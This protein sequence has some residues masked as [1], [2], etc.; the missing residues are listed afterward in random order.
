[1]IQWVW[2]RARRV[3]GLSRVLVATDDARIAAAAAG[4]GGEVVMTSPS[5]PSGSDRA[6]EAV[7]ELELRPRPQPPGRRA[8]PQPCGHHGLV[9]AWRADEAG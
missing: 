5:C 2:E 1:M 6:W 4:F 9:A 8:G 7:R 3:P